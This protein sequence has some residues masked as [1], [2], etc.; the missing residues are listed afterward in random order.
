MPGATGAEA[1]PASAAAAQAGGSEASAGSSAHDHAHDVGVSNSGAAT[2]ITPVVSGGGGDGVANGDEAGADDVASGGGGDGD[3]DDAEVGADDAA[4]GGMASGEQNGGR[5]KS[6]SYQRI[7]H[8]I[9]WGSAL[10]IH[11]CQR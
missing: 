10:R 2:E 11:A 1:T 7:S 3:A 9:R 6:L 5:R 8:A 4:G